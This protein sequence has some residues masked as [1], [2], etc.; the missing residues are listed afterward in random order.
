M[1]D[2]HPQV[3][4][5]NASIFV[6]S[7]VANAMLKSSMYARAVA[8]TC[9]AMTSADVGGEASS[10]AALV[11]VPLLVGLGLAITEAAD[12]VAGLGGCETGPLTATGERGAAASGA[13]L[14][15]PS[16][17]GWLTSAEQP[18]NDT[19]PNSTK[20]RVPRRY[21]TGGGYGRYRRSPGLSTG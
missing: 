13:E 14:A 20:R 5:V 6:T 19:T 7:P 1:S 12:D 4:D 15:L 17:L 16:A 10:V 2:R 21:P 8:R 18:A 3:G 11:G 9:I